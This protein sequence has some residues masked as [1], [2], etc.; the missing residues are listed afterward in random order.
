MRARRHRHADA[1]RPRGRCA[2][3]RDARRRRVSSLTR[4]HCRP[5]QIIPIHGIAGGQAGRRDRRA[6]RRRRRRAGHTARSTATASWSPRRSSRRPRTASSR[7]TPTTSTRAAALVES[8]SRAHGA[9]ARRLDDHRDHA[10]LRVRERRHRPVERRRRRTPRSSLSTP[11]VPRTHIRNALRA[12]RGVDV[13]VVV[14]DTFGRPW[15][16]GAHRRR[17][18]RRRHRRGRRPARHRPTRAAAMLQVTEVAI[19]D[20]IASAAE[21]VMGKAAGVPVAIV[22]GLDADLVRRRRRTRPR[23]RPRKRTCSGE[24]TMKSVPAFIEARRS[25]RAF[26]DEPVTRDVLDALVEAACLAPAPHHSRP[27]RWVVI[28]TDEGK[29]R[30]GRRHGRAAGESI[31]A[32]TASSRDRIDELVDASHRE[33]HRRAGARA[34]VPDLGR[35]RPLP[36]RGPPPRRVGHGAAVTRRRRREPHAR[37]GRRRPRVVLGRGADLLSRGRTRRAR[38]SRAVVARGARCSSGHPAP[39]VHAAANGPPVPLDELRADL[40]ERHC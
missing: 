8:E 21:L 20:E 30:A 7:S 31:S 6:H 10:R 29:A 3:P 35:P 22:R 39:D 14:S 2:R 23:P 40:A 26:T 15:R 25:I 12:R 11:T 32:A 16:H 33:D 5:A 38:T 1:R 34:R 4:D 37:C 28:D 36:R 9:T 13:A 27:W 24:R 19:A 17:H 18:R